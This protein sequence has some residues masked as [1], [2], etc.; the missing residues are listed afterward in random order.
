MASTKPVWASET[1]R[2]T[3]FRPGDQGAQ[4][5][6]PAGAV[7]DGPTRV[8]G[9]GPHVSIGSFSGS[10]QGLLVPVR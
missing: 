4:E 8:A 5:G 6:Q 3:P 7:P 1:T 10:G 2:W 9:I